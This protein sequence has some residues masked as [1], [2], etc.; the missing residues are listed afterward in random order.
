MAYT[1]YGNTYHNTTLGSKIE[2]DA[3]AY[4]QQ[5]FGEILKGSDCNQIAAARSMVKNLK[6]KHSADAVSG[7][8]NEKRANLKYADA[9]SRFQA[10]I[11]VKWVG[12]NCEQVIA[13]QD[14][15]EAVRRTQ[16]AYADIDSNLGTELALKEYLIYGLGAAVVLFGTFFIIL[17]KRKK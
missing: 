5:L 10:A 13:S 6:A 11:E 7:G 16:E 9:A 4:M 2:K 1:L 17:K 12:L 8:Y 3:E 15:D 14:E